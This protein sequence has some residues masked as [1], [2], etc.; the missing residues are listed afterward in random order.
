MAS[1]I[2]INADENDLHQG[3]QFFAY[4]VE[5][6]QHYLGGKDFELVFEPNGEDSFPDFGLW[7]DKFGI[8]Y[9]EVKHL[10]IRN[11]LSWEGNMITHNGYTS[12]RD[13]LKLS[14][15]GIVFETINELI[16]N[17]QVEKSKT[18]VPVTM[19]WAFTNIF[20]YEVEE[21]F[22]KSLLR[23]IDDIKNLH[24]VFRDDL[25]N[26][27]SL[28]DALFKTRLFKPQLNEKNKNLSVL[29]LNRTNLDRFYSINE[30]KQIEL[31]NFNPNSYQIDDITP[32]DKIQYHL[33]ND[34]IKN[35]GISLSLIHI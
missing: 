2:L 22:G 24:I 3:E 30:E 6:L 11:I 18:G 28:D 12:E 32:L 33:A 7:S 1:S 26:G 16:L 21:K 19:V 10:S 9:F 4:A 5:S 31:P 15:K 17:L 25:K 35:K 8:T 27:K 23:Q 13:T 34:L 29:Y 20:S 14:D